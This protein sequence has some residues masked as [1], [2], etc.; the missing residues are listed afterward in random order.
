MSTSLITTG[1]AD[2]KPK[3][4][5]SRPEGTLGMVALGVG[6]LA[7]VFALNSWLP[8]INSFL[9]MAITAV[10]KLAVL[11]GL[12]GVLAIVLYVLF[13]KRFQTLCKFVFM[14]GMRKITSVFIETDP[15]GIM[16]GYLTT[17]KDKKANLDAQK[18]QLS[19]QIR[20]TEEA[21]NT[22]AAEAKNALATMQ[23]AR[24]KGK[25]SVMQINARNAERLTDFNARLTNTLSKMRMIYTAL[26]KYSEAT[27]T[28]LEDIANE[29]R[30]REKERK[31]GLTT[32]SAISSAKAILQGAGLEKELYDEALEYLIDDFGMR[33]GE[34]DDFMSSS[35]T[36]MDGI[37]MQN[38]VWEAKA[39]AKLEAFE[40]TDSIVLGDKKRLM[41]EN[42]APN[43]L[44]PSF[45]QQGVPVSA[46]FDKFF[47][48]KG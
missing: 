34:I 37:D 27:D 40:S 36:I 43:T 14:S 46:G 2:Y 29:I 7:A 30:M 19:G 28:I 16:R 38:G 15:I 11:G 6:G 45:T 21:I 9:G 41:L 10:G 12:L 23:V 26:G 20:V 48:T 18:S 35:Q 42:Q 47:N 5:W 4:F 8:A 32:S 44:E 13:N 33:M 25:G 24:D 31:L 22:N 39:L 17:L 3:T 1:S